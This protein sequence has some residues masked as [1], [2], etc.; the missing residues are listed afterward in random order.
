MKLTDFC[1]LF[2]L[3]QSFMF[4]FQINFNREQQLKQVQVFCCG[5]FFFLIQVLFALSW[6]HHL[7]LVTQFRSLEIKTKGLNLAKL[8]SWVTLRDEFPPDKAVNGFYTSQFDWWSDIVS[9]GNEFCNYGSM[10]FGIRRQTVVSCQYFFWQM[11]T[12]RHS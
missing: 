7:V 9:F 4:S 10:A 5:F 1:K 6:Y 3:I 2:S 11:V 8:V 12:F